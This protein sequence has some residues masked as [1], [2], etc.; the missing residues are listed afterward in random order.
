MTP[1][2]RVRYLG[3]VQIWQGMTGVV[4]ENP[5]DEGYQQQMVAVHFD[6]YD[7]DNIRYA[8]ESNLEVLSTGLDENGDAKLSFTE[9]QMEF[10]ADGNDAYDG[11]QPEEFVVVDHQ[12]TDIPE[13]GGPDWV[14]EQKAPT[15][16]EF[17]Q[18]Y[19]D[20]PAQ[21]KV[22]WLEDKQ[23]AAVMAPIWEKEIPKVGGLREFIET[24]FGKERHPDSQRFHAWLKDAGDLHDM[25]QRDYG[26]GEDPFANVRRCERY[27]IPAWVGCAIRMA[28]KM[29]RIEKAIGQWAAGE[30]I[31]MSNESLLD[32]F[33]D[34]GVYAGIGKLL[35]EDTV[36][37]TPKETT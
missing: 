7:S 29:A 23:D 16:V 31:H 24:N 36:S 37:K 4:V 30:D 9:G 8:E 1:G 11:Q 27:G 32:S 13:D 2:T 10:I 25:K 15:F 5:A 21:P 17:G 19:L 35:Y 12:A 28:D 6:T 26:T 3:P 33:N 22:K 18:K 14:T 20:N 34:L